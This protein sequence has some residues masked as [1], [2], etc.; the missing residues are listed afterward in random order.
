M[1]KGPDFLVHLLPAIRPQVLLCGPVGPKLHELLDD[2]VFVPP[3]SL[4]EADEFH[5][6]LEY[7]AGKGS[8]EM[9]WGCVLRAC[10]VACL[11]LAFASSQDPV[12]FW[13]AALR[14]A[15]ALVSGGGRWTHSPDENSEVGA[16]NWPE[17]RGNR[18]AGKQAS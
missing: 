4:Q 7:Q 9:T 2:S 8:Q 18:A 15:V 16:Q 12:R 5:L 3:V 1:G 10:G 6:I 13:P 14:A 11:T 17:P